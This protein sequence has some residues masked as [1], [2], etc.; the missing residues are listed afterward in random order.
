MIGRPVSAVSRTAEYRYGIS[1]ERSSRYFAADRLDAV[2]CA[3]P[4]PGDCRR[5]RSSTFRSGRQLA[6]VPSPRQSQVPGAAVRAKQRAEGAELE[7]AHV[8]LARELRRRHEAADV[9]APIRNPAEPGVDPDWHVRSQRFPAWN[10]HPRTRGTRRSAPCQ[11]SRCGA[12]HT[13][14][15][16]AATAASLPSTCG[17]GCSRDG[18][19]RPSP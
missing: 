1:R 18:A 15:R 7:P 11:R 2:R 16:S 5:R 13:A 8:Q 14:V 3:A 4:I 6:R 10:R 12:A 17:S 9:R 19:S